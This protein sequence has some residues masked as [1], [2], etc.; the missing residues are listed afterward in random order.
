MPNFNMVSIV[1]LTKNEE[2]DLPGCLDSIQWC[3]DIHV[4]DSGSNDNTVA[5]AK[6][7]DASVTYRAFTSF[8]DQRNFALGNLQFRH[9]WILFLDAD[10]RSTDKF[11]AALFD[12]IKNSR[13][14]T[15]GYY[16]CWKLILQDKW[17]RFSDHFP[18]WQFRVTR[19]DY[20]CFTDFGHGQKE[21]VLR[22]KL[23]YIR[24]PYIHYGFSKGW[25]HW[26]QRHN[27]YSTDEAI[28]RLRDCPPFSQIFSSNSSKRNPAIK[29]W[30]VK[31]PGWPILR[32]TFSYFLHLGFLEGR[33]GFIY[34]V[35]MAYYEYLI[36]LKM[37][38]LLVKKK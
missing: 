1:V 17:L 11:R 26:L 33:Q 27:K 30:F 16:C 12:A 14:Q 13:D 8:G 2:K 9:E 6:S 3:D 5:I 22:G 32:F 10:E 24:E 4:L 28:A 21:K 18:R 19:K 34:C 36:K 20:S 38:E 35:N 7:K 15:A 29:S 23:A 31:M 37:H 25:Q